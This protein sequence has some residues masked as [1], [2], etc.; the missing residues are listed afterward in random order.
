[1]CA[2]GN[3]KSKRKAANKT[4]IPESSTTVFND[5]CRLPTVDFKINRGLRIIGS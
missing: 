2:F 3:M 5:D 4:N 1:M